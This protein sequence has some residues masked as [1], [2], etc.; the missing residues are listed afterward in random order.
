MCT[1]C[2]TCVKLILTCTGHT[3]TMS[4]VNETQRYDY[5]HQNKGSVQVWS[6]TNDVCRIESQKAMKCV[7]FAIHVRSSSSHV[8]VTLQPC[9]Q[10][11]KFKNMTISI[12]T[13]VV[14]KFE[15]SYMMCVEFRAKKLWNVYTL[16]YML[17]AHPHMCRSHFNDVASQRNS[18]VWLLASKQR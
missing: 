13:K 12:K 5:Q 9:R 7:H 11:T 15:A 14:F 2:H 8:Q 10:S 16:P 18:K 4:P 17:E 6:F 1:L 3:T